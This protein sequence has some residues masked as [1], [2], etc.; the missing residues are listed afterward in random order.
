MISSSNFN[1]LHPKAADASKRLKEFHQ[2]V[3]AESAR[4]FPT[5]VINDGAIA[6]RDLSYRSASVTYDFL[7][8]AWVLFNK[9]QT[10]DKSLGHP[11]ARMVIATGFRIQGRS[12]GYQST[13]SQFQILLEKVRS[14][15]IDMVEALQQA[16]RIRPSFDLIPQL[17]ANFAFT[18]AYVAEQSGSKGGLKGATCFVDMNLFDKKNFSWMRFGQLIDWKHEKLGLQTQ[19][20]ELVELRDPNEKNPIPSG[21]RNGLQVAQNL[22]DDK[23]VLEALRAARKSIGVPTTP[24]RNR[25]H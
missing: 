6:Y 16:R 22:A 4:T 1:P 11:G 2:T 10:T 12:A 18:K 5:L 25:K 17:Q 8:R 23:N 20:A 13:E 14:G 19:F 7:K 24:P 21:V 9:I 3:A 15:S